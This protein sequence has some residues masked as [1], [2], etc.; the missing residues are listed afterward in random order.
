M[1]H[2]TGY[3]SGEFV[4]GQVFH[5]KSALQETAKIYLIKA[6]QGFVVFASSKKLLVLRCKKAKECQCPWKL[7]SMLVKDTCLFVINRILV[8]ILA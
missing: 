4:V 8:S 3:L 7:R 1:K 2:S 6:H 5:S